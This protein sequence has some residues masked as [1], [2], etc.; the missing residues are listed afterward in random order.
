MRFVF[1]N[2]FTL[3]KKKKKKLLT[4]TYPSAN[5][6]PQHSF[7]FSIACPDVT[8]LHRAPR[9]SAPN[10]INHRPSYSLSMLSS[11][12]DLN[13]YGFS[14][15]STTA[16]LGDSHHCSPGNFGSLLGSKF[17]ASEGNPGQIIRDEDELSL[18]GWAGL[19]QEPA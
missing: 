6:L 14:P 18:P 8:V 17:P 3:F 10:I 2:S 19:H 12:V 11:H 16:A 9:L 13:S 15:L 7:I 4:S 1:F 5:K